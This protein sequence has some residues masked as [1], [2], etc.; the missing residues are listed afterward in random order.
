MISK[1]HSI[2][3]PVWIEA[4]VRWGGFEVTRKPSVAGANLIKLGS[5]TGPEPIFIN[6]VIG[7]RPHWWFTY[8]LWVFQSTEQLPQRHVTSSIWPLSLQSPKYILLGLLWETFANPSH[9]TMLSSK[10]FSDDGNVLYLHCPVQRP[11]AMCGCYPLGRNVTSDSHTGQQV[12][13]RIFY[14]NF[15]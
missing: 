8:L 12:K 2:D 6:S 9:K 14:F 11:L 1:E 5:Q 3:L 15:S 7:R 4:W 13:S 10:T